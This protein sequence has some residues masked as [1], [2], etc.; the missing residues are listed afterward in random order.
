M[1]HLTFI[2]LHYVRSVG[3]PGTAHIMEDAIFGVIFSNTFPLHMPVALTMNYSKTFIHT[4]ESEELGLHSKQIFCSPSS[5]IWSVGH[6]KCQIITWRS[7]SPPVWVNLASRM[8]SV[9]IF[10]HWWNSELMEVL[11]LGT[12][13][14][15]WKRE[16]G[17]SFFLIPCEI[18]FHLNISYPSSFIS[19]SIFGSRI[20]SNM[21]PEYLCALLSLC[22]FIKP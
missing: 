14:R 9:A 19:S 20:G 4:E 21:V 11:M 2:Q 16:I 22:W 15:R 17:A 13:E 5:Q 3:T 6:C 1:Q 10:C 8:H 18:I 7:L 12:C